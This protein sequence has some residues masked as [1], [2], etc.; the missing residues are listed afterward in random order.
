MATAYPVP[1][2]R[3]AANADVVVVVPAYNEA[4]AVGDV[5]RSL[6]GHFPTVV[7]VDDGSIDATSSEA[8]TAGATVVAHPT[9]L[10]QGAALQTGFAFA[11]T[12]PDVRWVVTFDADGQHRVD[13][14]LHLLDL[15]RAAGVDVVLG[16]RFLTIGQ[17]MPFVRRIVLRAGI[18]FTRL[19][20]GLPLTDTHNGLRVLARRA[21]ESMELTLVDMAHASQL[22]G[23]IARHE[24][25]YMEGPVTIDYTAYSRKRGQSNV[26]ALNIAFDLAVE[27][28]RGRR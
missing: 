16:S 10:G 3:G 2:T 21:V 24:L 11:L 27:R 12:D 5:V 25:T 19:T 15:A 8:R 4:G 26:N 7:C 17:R 23:R 22:L 14:A 20:T 1:M 13:D 6:R 9:N 18:T 28:L